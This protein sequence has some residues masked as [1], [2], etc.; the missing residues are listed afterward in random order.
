M[1]AFQ[2]ILCL[3][4]HRCLECQILSQLDFHFAKVMLFVL[5]YGPLNGKENFR[6]YQMG[7]HYLAHL[8]YGSMYAYRHVSESY[9]PSHLQTNH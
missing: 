3:D 1:L 6:S 5:L 4:A 2:N 8:V 7:N 9:L